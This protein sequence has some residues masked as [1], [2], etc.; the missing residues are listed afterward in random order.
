MG[1]ARSICARHPRAVPTVLEVLDPL[2]AVQPHT[3]V[4]LSLIPAT[5]VALRPVLVRV[6]RR[7][8]HVAGG[9]K[10]PA[11]SLEDGGE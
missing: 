6:P 11:G 4:F 5:V 3:V 9:A 1:D 10:A 2:Q 8:V 7:T